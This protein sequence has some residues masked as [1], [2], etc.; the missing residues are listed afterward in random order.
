M[1]GEN[2]MEHPMNKWDELGGF[3]PTPIFGWKH[4]YSLKSFQ[5]MQ[6]TI[7]SYMFGFLSRKPVQNHAKVSGT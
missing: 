4:P 1:D 2:F 3:Q 5:G 7:P 6:Q